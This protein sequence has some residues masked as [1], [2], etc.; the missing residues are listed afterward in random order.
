MNI[1]RVRITKKGRCLMRSKGCGDS[2]AEVC[3]EVLDFQECNLDQPYSSSHKIVQYTN[4]P[5]D[6]SHPC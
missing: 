6:Q 3:F 4:G 2:L 5:F 1:L